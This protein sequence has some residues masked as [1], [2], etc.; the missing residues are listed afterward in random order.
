MGVIFLCIFSE[1]IIKS[2][3]GRFC[4]LKYHIYYPEFWLKHKFILKKR[5]CIHFKFAFYN[6]NIKYV[7]IPIMHVKHISASEYKLVTYL[8]MSE[9]FF[10][11]SRFF[12]FLTILETCNDQYNNVMYTKDMHLKFE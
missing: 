8:L 11:K 6:L 1:Y 2:C 12:S 10:W 5:K 4:S 9:I 3:H 7:K